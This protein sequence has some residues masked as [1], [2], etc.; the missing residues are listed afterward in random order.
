MCFTDL[1]VVNRQSPTIHSFLQD[2]FVY[3]VAANRLYPVV[4]P[5]ADPALDR[6]THSPVY[7]AVKDHFTPP[8][9]HSFASS[10]LPAICA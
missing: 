3:Q 10:S 8:V 1:C 2:T 4:S 7:T 9:D 5:L 6:L